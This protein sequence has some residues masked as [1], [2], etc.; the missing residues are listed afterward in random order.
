MMKIIIV[1]VVVLVVILIHIVRD[2]EQPPP[3]KA[4]EP[5]FDDYA[6]LLHRRELAPGMIEVSLPDGNYIG[7]VCFSPKLKKWAATWNMFPDWGDQERYI[8]DC[9]ID[10]ERELMRRERK[11]AARLAEKPVKRSTHA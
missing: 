7:M 8:W 11:H 10:A 2:R 5:S 6:P 4:L 3:T 9:Q 1:A